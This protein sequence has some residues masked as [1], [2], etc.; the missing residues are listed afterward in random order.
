MNFVEKSI[1]INKETRFRNGTSERFSALRGSNERG[2]GF[3]PS[4]FSAIFERERNGDNMSEQTT[5]EQTYSCR[6]PYFFQRRHICSYCG[7]IYGYPISGEAAGTS[8]KSEAA[9]VEAEKKLEKIRERI[10]LDKPRPNCGRY[11]SEALACLVVD[12]VG[13]QI[14]R[15]GYSSETLAVLGVEYERVWGWARVSADL[16]RR[17]RRRVF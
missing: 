3:E 10:A 4:G 11:S 9:R 13:V 16:R 1:I 7:A 2:G 12:D 14:E 8:P 5:S 6:L 15:F 17:S